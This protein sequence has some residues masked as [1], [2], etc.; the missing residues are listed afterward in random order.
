MQTP[1]LAAG[2]FKAPV[3]V[4]KQSIPDIVPM[5]RGRPTT[6]DA[7]SNAS[8]PSPSP[9]RN[10]TS[11][12]F[13][14][15]DAGK[16]ST[17]D[18]AT[19]EDV[20]SRFPALDEFSLLHDSGSKFAFDSESTPVKKDIKQQVTNALADDAFA[21]PSTSAKPAPSKQPS[22]HSAVEVKPASRVRE[23]P[24]SIDTNI[25]PP[26]TVQQKPSSYVSTGTM[27]SNP[28]SPTVNTRATSNRQIFRFPPSTEGKPFPEQRSSDPAELA[29]AR[30][31]ADATSARPSQVDSQPKQQ[32]NA[33][34][35]S[36]SSRPSFEISHRS[37]FL[38]GFDNSLHRSRSA[39][40]KSRPSSMQGPSKPGIFRRLSR[41]KSREPRNEELVQETEMLTSNVTGN[42]EDGEEAAKIDS[43]VDYLKALEEAEAAKKK[44]K[45]LSSG[46]RH[47]KRASMPSVSLS[48][49]KNLLAGRFGEAFRRYETNSEDPS[50]GDES[51]Q[52][53]HLGDDMPLSPIVGSEATDG[54]SD[55]GNS[56]EESEEVPPE[57]R[58]ELERR[59]LE[60]EEKRVA[61]AAAAYRQR[62]TGGGKSGGA[63]GPNQKAMSIQSKVRSLLD[64]S[65]R[66]SPSPTRTAEGYGKYTDQGPS[67]APSNN[68]PRTSSRQVSVGSLPNGAGQM[69][70]RAKPPPNTPLSLASRLENDAQQLAS[71][72]THAPVDL[73]RHSAPPSENPVTRPTGPPKPQPKPPALRTVD[74]IPS[75][76]LKPSSLTSRKSFSTR[77]PYQTSPAE[78]P[79]QTTPTPGNLQIDGAPADEDW[80]N[81]FSKRYPDLSGLGLVETDIDDK[82]YSRGSRTGGGS[83][84][85]GREMKIRDV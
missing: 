49:T 66:A 16:A 27:T 35:Q 3:V 70:S 21:F 80:E 77:N 18:S 63:P 39:T 6:L 4:E 40:T 83:S 76:P 81:N 60:Q 15:L 84:G 25:V 68:P 61:D 73:P 54:R 75:S 29:A 28:P 44:E 51:R 7:K 78:Q 22:T 26:S 8:K 23:T 55:D 13:S 31:R 34:E 12:P 37:S 20:S 1:P 9:L 71:V 85:P 50:H 10:S 33:A 67:P 2:A 62:L 24:S 19:F 64:E 48:G 53:I 36:L 45:R 72:S 57:V 32:D 74:R 52:P 65:G 47:F 5:R 38:G 43:N 17:R 59:R 82:L 79:D 30:L 42:V 41:E 46:S 56:L 11:D 58:R 69:P 14:V